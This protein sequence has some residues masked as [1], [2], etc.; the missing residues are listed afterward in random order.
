MQAYGNYDFEFLGKTKSQT[1]IEK[2]KHTK[3][4]QSDRSLVVLAWKL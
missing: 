3:A 1:I 2:I 4:E